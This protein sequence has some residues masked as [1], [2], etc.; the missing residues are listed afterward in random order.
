MITIVPWADVGFSDI[1]PVIGITGTPV[2]DL[3]TNIAYLVTKTKETVGRR[4]HLATCKRPPRHQ[5]GQRHRC[6][7]ALHDR[8]DHQRQHQQHTHLPLRRR[9]PARSPTP[10]T[11]PRQQVVQF[12]RPCARTS[13]MALSLVNGTVYVSWASHG[14]NGPYHG[15]VVAWNVANITTTGFGNS[16]SGV[17]DTSPTG[18]EA[19]VWQGGAALDLRPRRPHRADLLL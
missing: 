15:W 10:T 3:T 13:C 8:L 16:L 5:P 11:A 18:S 1:S 2:I 7:G 14:D 12:K 9:G 6:C 17:L 19:G 4:A